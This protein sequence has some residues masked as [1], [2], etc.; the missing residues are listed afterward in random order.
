[1]NKEEIITEIKTYLDQHLRNM[2][3]SIYQEP[4]KGD[5]FRLFRE[6]YRNGYC[7]V[8]SPRPFTGDALSDIIEQRWQLGEQKQRYSLMEKLFDMWD[9]WRYAWD[10]YDG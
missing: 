9:E 1:M 4:Y 10:H 2:R 7:D 6:A 5:F 8:A 3:G